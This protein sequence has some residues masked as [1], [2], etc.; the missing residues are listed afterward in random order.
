LKLEHLMTIRHSLLA[1][2]LALAASGAAFAQD[3]GQHPA[4]FSPRKAIGIDASTFIVAHPASL[5]WVTG[6][7]NAEHPATVGRGEAIP[8]DVNI[9]LVQPPAHVDWIAPVLKPVAKLDTAV[10]L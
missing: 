3:V 6:H 7:A 10:V 5:H 4:V 2:V 8:V 1:S 9:F